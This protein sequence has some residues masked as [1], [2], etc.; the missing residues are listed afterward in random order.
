MSSKVLLYLQLH[1]PQRINKLSLFDFKNNVKK[2]DLEKRYFNKKLDKT[3][4]SRVLNSSYLPFL[5]KLTE[6]N[7]D[8]NLGITGVLLQQFNE[9]QINLIKSVLC[10]DSVDFLRETSYH[11][12]ASMYDLDEFKEQITEH[13]RLINK[14][15]GKRPIA[16]RNTE[17]LTFKGLQN[18]ILEKGY[19]LSEEIAGQQPRYLLQRNNH[20]SDAIGFRLKYTLDNIDCYIEE[21]MAVEEDVIVLGIDFET[22]GEHYDQELSATF[23]EN[24]VQ[25]FKKR[26]GKFIKVSDL[27]PLTV[28]DLEKDLKIDSIKSWA[29]R[30]KDDSAWRGNEMQSSSLD[31]LYGLKDDVL[32]A[33]S[34]DVLNV[35]RKLQ[36]SDHF[37][38]M[39]SKKDDDGMVHEYF[40]PF[41]T[42]HDAY[43]Y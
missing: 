5:K 39:S 9:E 16:F 43:V 34:K 30:D 20:L 36:T 2:E 12:L 32:S 10:L 6:L 28:Q 23:I 18:Y 25:K 3:I 1:Q 15:F 38:Y 22:F 33:D 35:W 37:Y 11:S 14:C 26:G 40:S 4:F 42:P 8:F 17:L 19:L 13:T 29:D 21:I 31:R 24:F 7:I 41:N 27:P